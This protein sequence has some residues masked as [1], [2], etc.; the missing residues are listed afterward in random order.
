MTKNEN[1]IKIEFHPEISDDLEQKYISGGG[2]LTTHDAIHLILL[3]DKIVHG[4]PINMIQKAELEVILTPKTAREIGNLLI[5]E[6]NKYS[7]DMIN[8]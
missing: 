6:S 2:V 7:E 8:E 4:N 5:S 1:E 3:S